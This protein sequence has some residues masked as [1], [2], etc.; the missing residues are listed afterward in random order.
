MSAQG[1]RRRRRRSHGD[2]PA[3]SGMQKR[4]HEVERS[5]ED[6]EQL[7]KEHDALELGTSGL[8]KAEEREVR[9]RRLQNKTQL[10]STQLNST[11]LN[12]TQ[13]NST[14]LD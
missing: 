11:Q 12:S 14:Q 3:S 7:E 10:N 13:L 2:R 6:L 9:T 5:K 4:E 8:C 1:E